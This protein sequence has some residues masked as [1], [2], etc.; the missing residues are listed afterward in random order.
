MTFPSRLN[1]KC[2]IDVR[3]RWR[4]QARQPPQSEV[5]RQRV[6]RTAPRHPEETNAVDADHERADVCEDRGR[7]ELSAGH[8]I[9]NPQRNSEARPEKSDRVERRVAQEKSEADEEGREM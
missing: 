6:P 3:A 5:R 8:D 4:D 9:E 2:E 1:V 7:H